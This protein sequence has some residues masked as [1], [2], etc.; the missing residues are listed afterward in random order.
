MKTFLKNSLAVVVGIF[1]YS[2]I[3]G[4]LGSIFMII[5]IA[6][7][8]S[9]DKVEVKKNSILHVE[10]NLP[11]EDRSSDNFMENIDFMSM[12]Q[13]EYIGLNDVLKSIKKAEADDNIK[14]IYLELTQIQAGMPAI[15]EIRNAIIKFKES[16]KFVVAY[17][18]YYSHKTYYL[19]SIAD[20]IYMTP[21]GHF[22]FTG[23]SIQS[24][25]FKNALD[26]MGVEAQ[27][28][29]HGKFKSA[30]EPF[31]LDE[32][33]ES[34]RKQMETYLFAVWNH[35]TENIAE[36]RGLTTEDLNRYADSLEITSTQSSVDKKLVDA[37]MYQDQI[38]E[39][40]K[41]RVEIKANKKLRLVKMSSY[42]KSL[43]NDKIKIKDDNDKIAII[44]AIGEIGMGEGSTY[45]IGADG[46]S[47]AIRKAR[48]DSS[49]KA[50]VLRIDSPGGS[51]LASEI[52]WREIVL[53]KEVKPVVVSMGKYAASG[54]YYIACPADRIIASPN[55]LTGSIGVF[56]MYPNVKELLNDKIGINVSTVKTNEYSDMPAFT[57]PLS[58]TEKD[59]LQLFVEDIYGVF[60]EHVAEGR[61]MTVAQVDSIGQGRIWSGI[62]AIEI[63]LVDELGGLD[64]AIEVAEELANISDYQIIELPKIKDP[65]EQIM[66]GLSTKAETFVM[67]KTLG[68]SYQ[69]YMQLNKITKMQGIQARMMFNID[70]N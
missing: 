45:A 49:V 19:A 3:M 44:Y 25:F 69:Y 4:I 26:K 53:A 34:N 70:I 64:R 41:S 12:S 5:V 15:E 47:S 32:M 46:M 66:E 10:L 58:Q 22:T 50:I 35:F 51:A 36:S 65:F 21:S 6:A 43:G 68:Q 55:T 11:I 48:K 18:N 7:A 38:T 13:D 42:I 62:N 40:L 1:I 39:E 57:R 30:V 14:G 20:K 67:K 29:R 23:F 28:I 24:M 56:G 61:N 33:S 54:G 8:S 60:I 31:I 59:Y 17:S 16:G 63:G 37:L 27:I 52:I 2:T 9:D